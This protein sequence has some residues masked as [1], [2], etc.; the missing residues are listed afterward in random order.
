[1]SQIIIAV[2][3]VLTLASMVFAMFYFAKQNY[4]IYEYTSKHTA[5]LDKRFKD[6]QNKVEDIPTYSISEE[7][8]EKQLQQEELFN[9]GLKN[10]IN[11]NAMIKGDE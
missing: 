9:E 7:L 6:L 8:L 3:A 2:W 4:K 11:Y 10:I 5:E 1:M